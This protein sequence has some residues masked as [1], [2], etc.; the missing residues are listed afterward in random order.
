MSKKDLIIKYGL[1]G[2][3]N[4]GLIMAT[5]GF[6]VGFAAVSLYGPVA[7]NFNNVMHMSGVLLGLLV[8]APNLTGSLLRIPFGAWVDRVGGKKPMLTL[9]FLSV[10]G[11]AGLTL[12]L[13]FYYPEK[14]SIKMYPIIFIFGLLSGCGIATFS[15]GI[16]QTSYWFPQKK[17][18]FALGTYAGLGNTA[19][20][21]FGII[22]PVILGAIGLTGAYASWFL[23]LLTGTIIYLFFANDAYYF[24]LIQKGVSREEAIKISKELGQELFPSGKV[25][26]S[27]KISAKVPKTWGLVVL[28]FISFGGFLALTAWFPTYWIEL[29]NVGIRQAGLLMAFGFSLLASFIR[30]YGGFL[31]D[32]IGGEKTAI[33]SYSIVF[34]G[35]FILVFTNQF[36]IALIGE[37]TISIGMGIANAA[38]F[39]LVPKYVPNAPGGASGWVG[40]LGAFGGF[41]VPPLLGIFVDLFG[42]IGYAKGFIVYMLLAVIG[43]VISVLLK[44]SSQGV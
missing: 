40:G 17:Q 16:P 11:M 13:Y 24:Q 28:Y 42:K 10:I 30:V 29:H 25:I 15:V 14:I 7:K 5:F 35:A 44:K 23:F 34:I 12:V 43:I 31:S 41:V 22:L 27:L 38:V 4:S 9:L 6:F 8:A 2:T 19:P 33:I 26:E 32:K 18:G 36:I 39:K 1:K 20:G 21:I 37:I 3:P